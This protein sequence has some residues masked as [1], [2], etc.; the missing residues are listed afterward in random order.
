[1]GDPQ[2]LHARPVDFFGGE[3]TVRP[4]WRHRELDR[5]DLAIFIR[6]G[7]E[8]DDDESNNVPKV[9]KFLVG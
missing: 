6:S 4:L 5:N 9:A 2:R 7:A 8:P 3:G 1:V